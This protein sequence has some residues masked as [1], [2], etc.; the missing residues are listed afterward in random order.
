MCCSVQPGSPHEGFVYRLPIDQPVSSNLREVFHYPTNSVPAGLAFG[1]SGKVYVALFGVSQTK[2]GNQISI[3]SPDGT[4][5]ARFPSPNEN[6]KQTV[7]YDGP[8]GLAFDGNGSLLVTNSAGD[9]QDP[10]HWVVLEAFVNDT[11]LPLL[12]PSIP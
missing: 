5:E 10:H 8:L 9:T 12:R 4:E 7:P 1:S 3:L 2:Q 6:A 11:A